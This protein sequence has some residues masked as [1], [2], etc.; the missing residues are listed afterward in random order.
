MSI[1]P[2]RKS[3]RPAVAAKLR[4]RGWHIIGRA[5]YERR[6]E[7]DEVSIDLGCVLRIAGLWNALPRSQKARVKQM[8]PIRVMTA[9][10]VDIVSDLRRDR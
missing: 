5:A 9:T 8:P 7:M 2:T 10:R 3:V 1:D 6:H 4:K